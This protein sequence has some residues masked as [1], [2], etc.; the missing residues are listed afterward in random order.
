LKQVEFS[1]QALQSTSNRSSLEDKE[2]LRQVVDAVNQKGQHAIIFGERGVGKTSLANVLSTFLTAGRVVL[3]PR[4]NCDGLDSFKSLWEK[5]F[6]QIRLSRPYQKA[7]FTGKKVTTVGP[8]T[9]ELDKGVSPDSVRRSLTILAASS[10]PVLIF[11]EFDRLKAE[12]KHVFADTIKG[13]RPMNPSSQRPV[14]AA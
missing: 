13:K 2:Q 14:R 4:V 3:S 7:G 1:L 6:E 10:L 9:A 11:D 12:I 8:W 5:A